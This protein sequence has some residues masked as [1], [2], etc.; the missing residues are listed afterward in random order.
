MK[1]EPHRIYEEPPHGVRQWARDEAG[2]WWTRYVGSFNRSSKGWCLSASAPPQPEILRLASI[3]KT[4]L[5]K[6]EADA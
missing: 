6:L 5:P 4:R 1:I 2:R 3:K